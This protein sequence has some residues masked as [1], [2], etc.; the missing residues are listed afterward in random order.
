M[1]KQ[2]WVSRRVR[3]G[4]AV[5]TA[6]ALSACGGSPSEAPDLGSAPVENAVSGVFPACDTCGAADAST[7]VPGGAAGV[8][9]VS[10]EGSSAKSVP[11][12]IAGLTGQNVTLMLTNESASNVA[13]ASTSRSFALSVPESHTDHYHSDDPFR[14]TI[15]KFNR[16]GWS[17]LLSDAR[18]EN[19]ASLQAVRMST[20]APVVGTPRVWTNCETLNS[21]Y[22]CAD[23]NP[24]RATTL[25]AT[26]TA[27]D[28]RI[29]NVWVEDGERGSGKFND[30]MAQTLATLYARTGG[31]HD[32]LTDLGGA[33]WG[34]HAY[35]GQLISDV[36][37]P[38]DIVMLNL[39]PDSRSG[40]LLGYFWSLN[41]FLKSQAPAS[42]EALALFMDTETA[43]LS[44]QGMD[45]IRST[46]V[47]EGMHLTNYYRRAIQMGVGHAFDTWLEEMSAMMAEDITATRATPG[48]N[49][50][51]DERIPQYLASGSFNCNPTTFST[52]GFTCF[53]YSVNGSLGAYLLR[54]HGVA[55][56]KNML[57]MP[58]V[59]SRDVLEGALRSVAPQTTLNAEL[60]RWGQS[61]WPT[62]AA[63]K[64]PS[65][66]GYPSRVE[67]SYTL[68]GLDLQA[69][70]NLRALPT[71][72]STG[73]V[74]PGGM[75]PWVRYGVSGTFEETVTVP[76]GTTL[77][78]VVN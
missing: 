37:R 34:S 24:D 17:K 21:S 56:Y 67:G 52:S 32:M 16:E 76:A 41:N 42:N 2:E 66:F 44:P 61:A 57:A 23:A 1:K 62:T 10:N 8:W 51:L 31:V 65:G 11:V 36:N 4:L 60:R 50:I 54:Q 5:L 59:R 27:S 3:L 12:S 25:V 73:T 20:S 78:V 64:M 14:A 6:M 77:S 70:R 71:S 55:F 46:L 30:S 40:G 74:V 47:H 45:V 26:A 19:P 48:Y 13:L 18:P 38:V 68:Q 29:V 9:Q 72:P 7:F 69:L 39:T 15:D 35:S 33:P 28:G 53:G 49:N 22:G 63:S 58:G 43:Y 75:V